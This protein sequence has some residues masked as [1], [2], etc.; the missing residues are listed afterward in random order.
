MGRSQNIK[1]SSPL[2]L[3][4]GLTRNLDATCHYSYYLLSAESNNKLFYVWI[5]F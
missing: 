3:H 5:G 4:I 1:V 2:K